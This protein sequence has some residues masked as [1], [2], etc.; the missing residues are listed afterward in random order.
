MLFPAD[1]ALWAQH[2]ASLTRP[3]GPAEPGA[4]RSIQSKASSGEGGKDGP[5]PAVAANPEPAG[6]GPTSLGQPSLLD[7][8]ASSLADMSSTSTYNRLDS[9]Q[10]GFLV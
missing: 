1:R 6:E 10:V 3:P 4:R 2:K 9:R 7:D 8:D 5:V